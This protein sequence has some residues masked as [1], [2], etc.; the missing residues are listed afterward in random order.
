MNIEDFQNGVFFKYRGREFRFERRPLTTIEGTPITGAEVTG[1]QWVHNGRDIGEFLHMVLIT[2]QGR[3]KDGV[4]FWNMI[5]GI[6]LES[7]AINPKELE[8]ITTPAQTE[9]QSI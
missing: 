8:L 4:K 5:S 3:R 6:Y 7:E 9:L 2:K 1:C